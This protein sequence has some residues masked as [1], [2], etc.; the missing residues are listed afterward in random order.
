MAVDDPQGC[1]WWG[2]RGGWGGVIFQGDVCSLK[3]VSR[4]AVGEVT[5]W[6]PPAPALPCSPRFTGS[7]CPQNKRIMKHKMQQTSW[8]WPSGTQRMFTSRYLKSSSVCLT[9]A[10]TKMARPHS[11]DNSGKHWHCLRGNVWERKN[12][13]KWGM[14]KDLKWASEDLWPVMS[15][16]G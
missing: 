15:D 5:L 9:T 2:W 11:I 3:S 12:C 14:G 4:G 8:C 10:K 16:S 13:V 1:V 6:S 7:P